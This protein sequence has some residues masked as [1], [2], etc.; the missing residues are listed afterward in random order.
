[1]KK[2]LLF[3]MLL[4]S[5]TMAMAQAAASGPSDEYKTLCRQ[6]TDEVNTNAAFAPGTQNFENYVFIAKSAAPGL[7][8]AE[9]RRLTENYMNVRMNEISAE[10]VM[11]FYQ[12]YLSVN[13]LKQVLA[14]YRTPAGKRIADGVIKMQAPEVQGIISNWLS[15]ALMSVM[16]G[17]KVDPAPC[18]Q[19][20][21]FMKAFDRA[22]RVCDFRSTLDIMLK[23][24][25]EAL[26][27][28]DN[29]DELY[30]QMATLMTQNSRALFA[31]MYGMV[32]THE[33]M[34]ALASFYET[35]YGV[36]MAKAVKEISANAV[37]DGMRI[38][39]DFQNWIISHAE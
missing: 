35:Q 16:M 14:F 31:E 18:H 39:N 37:N 6:I 32:Y 33:D 20:E 9:A 19:S 21:A 23:N 12:K 29:G 28:M 36:K 1:M 30:E 34:E 5:A 24:M 27:S 26:V 7:T 3:A 10:N 13:D 17:G 4:L 25:K 8:D 2:L 11:P 15:P 38:V 22:D